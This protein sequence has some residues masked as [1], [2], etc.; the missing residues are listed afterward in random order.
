MYL[1]IKSLLQEPYKVNEEIFVNNKNE[2]R[3]YQNLLQL[4]LPKCN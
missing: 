1:E 2:K 3:V 4:K